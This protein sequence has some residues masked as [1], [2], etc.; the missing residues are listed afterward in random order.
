MI[1][2]KDDFKKRR[3]VNGCNSQHAAL[4]STGAEGPS[5]TLD[6]NPHGKIQG[7]QIVKRFEEFL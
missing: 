2:K 7:G 6:P 4:L 3:S 1:E 5:S